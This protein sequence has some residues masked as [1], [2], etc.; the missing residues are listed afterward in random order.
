MGKV[1]P[2][3]GIDSQSLLPML[4][5]ENDYAVRD[6][7]FSENWFGKMVV[8]D[9]L[10][11]VYYTGREYGELYDLQNDPLERNNFWNEKT[12]RERKQGLKERL[13]RWLTETEDIRPL[14]IR[15]H[16]ME[17]YPLRQ[18]ELNAAYAY[19]EPSETQQWF[20]EDLRDLYDSWNFSE[21]GINR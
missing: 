6:A 10:K 17:Q 15:D 16:D 3:P 4:R 20:L 13:L 14:P 21:P 5:G 8:M 1:N 11:L 7:V 19:P 12:C 9:H 2:G 18:L